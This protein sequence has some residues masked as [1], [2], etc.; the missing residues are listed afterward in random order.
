MDILSYKKVKIR[1]SHRCFCCGEKH[2]TGSLMI[3]GEY[4]DG[5]IYSLHTCLACDRIMFEFPG[6]MEDPWDHTISQGAFYELRSS[7]P[8]YTGMKPIELLECLRS[9]KL[10][11]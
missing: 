11:K 8:K 9:E 6:L 5:Y 7:D 2:E 1:K 10:I 3:R 4:V